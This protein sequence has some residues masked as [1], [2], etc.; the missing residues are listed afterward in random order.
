MSIDLRT[1]TATI[2]NDTSKKEVK[3]FFKF[4]SIYELRKTHRALQSDGAV[5]LSRSLLKS[6]AGAFFLRLAAGG[7]PI[8]LVANARTN[9]SI[10]QACATDN[11]RL[12]K[13]VGFRYC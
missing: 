9:G 3:S 11:H 2:F 13:G 1:L 8:G 5:A 6:G 4:L 12:R 10:T 7:G